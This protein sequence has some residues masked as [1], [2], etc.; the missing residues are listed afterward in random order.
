MNLQQEQE[1][2]LQVFKDIDPKL[3]DSKRNSCD[4]DCPFIE[5]HQIG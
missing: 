3:I 2:F 4:E 1:F 5:K